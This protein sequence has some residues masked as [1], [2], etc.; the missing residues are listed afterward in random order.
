MFAPKRFFRWLLLKL[1]G[2]DPDDICRFELSGED[3]ASC[4]SVWPVPEEKEE[5]GFSRFWAQEGRQVIKVNIYWISQQ[6]VVEWCIPKMGAT[7]VWQ[8][9]AGVS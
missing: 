7:G 6:V 2:P 4:A 8:L 3:L 9:D 1:W 5:T